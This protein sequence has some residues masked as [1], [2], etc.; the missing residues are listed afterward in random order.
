MTPAQ[1]AT[2]LLEY[3]HMIKAETS[4]PEVLKLCNRAIEEA[5]MGVMRRGRRK[6]VGKYS[7]NE[8]LIRW[9]LFYYYKTEQNQSQVART[10]GVS[11]GTAQKIIETHG[12][13]W[14][15]WI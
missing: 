13:N 2:R 11:Q 15:E 10:C 9:V 12:K 3:I 14:R 6:A 7:T 1:K 5:D 8:E 4:Q